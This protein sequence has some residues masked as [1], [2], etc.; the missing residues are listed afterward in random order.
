MQNHISDGIY[1]HQHNWFYELPSHIKIASVF[2]FVLVVVLTPGHFFQA[3]L[4]YAFIV[5]ALLIWNQIPLRSIR[6]RLIIEIPF[7]LFA[8]FLPIFGTDPRIDFFGFKLSEPGLWAGWNIL[9]KA[10]IGVMMS[11][12]LSSTTPQREL[13]V[14]LEKLKFPKLLVQIMSFMIRY[15]V[16]V[17][18]ELKRMAIARESRCFEAKG[19]KQWGVLARSAGAL[20][21]RS[22]ERGE[23]VHMAMLSRGYTGTLPL[24]TIQFSSRR[25]RING[26]LLPLIAI[27]VFL[28]WSVILN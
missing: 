22:Y 20:F 1:K 2:S 5:I 24:T 13:L 25:D 14:G 26:T 4:T 16:V 21:I 6:K 9:I 23:R 7:V 18:E 3:H 10:T 15:T 27:I 11:L 28:I 8:F 19:P 17:T 12:I